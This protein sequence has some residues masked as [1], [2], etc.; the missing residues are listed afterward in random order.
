MKKFLLAVVLLCFTIIPG[1]FAQSKD[2]TAGTPNLEDWQ[3]W[4][5]VMGR[6]QQMLMESWAEGLKTT[7]PAS[8]AMAPPWG[9]FP[10]AF[11]FGGGRG[12]GASAAPG[13]RG[14][15]ANGP[16]PPE[17]SASARGVDAND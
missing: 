5:W 15:T 9:A 13:G 12:G 2:E 7:Q 17:G 1:S 3:H 11:G 4:T 16:T 14:A 10:P 8:A 6:A